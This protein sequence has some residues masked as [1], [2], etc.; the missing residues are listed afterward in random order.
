METNDTIKVQLKRVKGH[1]QFYTVFEDVSRETLPLDAKDRYSHI[2]SIHNGEVTIE[3]VPSDGKRRKGVNRA[4]LSKTNRLPIVKS[5]KDLPVTDEIPP[6][7]ILTD[8]RIKVHKENGLV[9]KTTFLLPDTML[10]STMEMKEYPVDIPLKVS[11]PD[12]NRATVYL[13]VSLANNGKAPREFAT[14]VLDGA[15]AI[16]PHPETVPVRGKAFPVDLILPEG[17]VFDRD[18]RIESYSRKQCAILLSLS[19]SPQKVNEVSPSTEDLSPE[20]VIQKGV[21]NINHTISSLRGQFP[22]IEIQGA[23]VSSGD[24]VQIQGVSDIMTTRKEFV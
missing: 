18:A 5:N 24:K 21:N 22:E 17:W 23:T 13:P 8:V 20:E 11:I 10:P 19:S 15:L 3:T 9:Q 7:G 2:L 6:A 4:K 16:V 12:P 14:F 1:P